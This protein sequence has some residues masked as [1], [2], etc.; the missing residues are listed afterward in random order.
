MRFRFSKFEGAEA[1]HS[2]LAF[3]VEFPQVRGFLEHEPC[4]LQASYL[5]SAVTLGS[6]GP[7]NLQAAHF[8]A[9][10]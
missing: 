3:S 7:R 2:Q 5:L 9:L 4:G 10:K 8:V 1:I 6:M